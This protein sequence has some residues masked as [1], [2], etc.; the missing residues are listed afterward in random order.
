M[1]Y[2]N[3]GPNEINLI[4][5]NSLEKPIENPYEIYNNMIDKDNYKV[6]DFIEKINYRHKLQ[7]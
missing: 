4:K 5:R 3:S 1:I 6:K 2:K 7:I